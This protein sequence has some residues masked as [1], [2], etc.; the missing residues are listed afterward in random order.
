MSIIRNRKITS[1]LYIKITS[2]I[3]DLSPF[4]LGYYLL[5]YNS[6]RKHEGRST[7]TRQI[8]TIIKYLSTFLSNRLMFY[9]DRAHPLWSRYFCLYGFSNICKLKA[10]IKFIEEV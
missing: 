3:M 8:I 9:T 5:V 4:T 10:I 6:T 7:N 2:N 1:K